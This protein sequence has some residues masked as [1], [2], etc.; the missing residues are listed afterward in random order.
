MQADA[1]LE[2]WQCSDWLVSLINPL[3]NKMTH[4][5]L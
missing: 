1:N 3:S 4:L 5:G 2:H